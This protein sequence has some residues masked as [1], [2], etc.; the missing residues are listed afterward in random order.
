MHETVHFVMRLESKYLS[1]YKAFIRVTNMCKADY[2]AADKG[3]ATWSNLPDVEPG[4][5]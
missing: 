1:I 2:R 5:P 3:E 4:V